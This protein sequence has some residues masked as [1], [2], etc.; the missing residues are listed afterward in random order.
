[1]SGPSPDANLAELLSQWTRAFGWRGRPAFLCGDDVYTHGEVHRGASRV[2]AMLAAR[3]ATPG[4]R[5]AIALPGSI[6]FVWAFLGAI[7]LGAVATLADPELPALPEAELAV[8]APGRHPRTVTAAELTAGMPRAGLARAHPVLPITPAFVREGVM[9]AHGD[10]E[11]SYLAMQSLSSI[12][13]RQDDV[14]LSVY[15]PVGLC[16]TVF[17]PLFCGA[18]AVLEPGLRSVSNVAER[19]RKHRA[20]VLMSSS[21]FLGRIAA[22]GEG[23][24]FGP[25]RMAISHGTAPPPSRA[26][27]RLGCPVVT[28]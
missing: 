11:A 6:E 21:S 2:A 28:P 14:L 22:E 8:C 24:T 23:E 19:L 10:P 20:S 3:G 13:L 16:D 17:L 12:R 27:Q 25:L 26:A 18:S 5:V 1:M 15:D 4:D 7:R 9:Y